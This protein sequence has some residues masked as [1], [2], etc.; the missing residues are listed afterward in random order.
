M[1]D[2]AWR[3]RI[4]GFDDVAPDQL[5]ANP[6]NWR[7]HPKHQQDALSGVLDQVGWVQSVLVNKRTGFVVDGHLRVALALRRN[8]PTVPVLYVDLSEDEEALVL[9][10]L[11]PIGALATADK[12]KLD[13]LLRDVD[14]GSAAVQAMLSELAER[15][16][17][18]DTDSGAP[19]DTI[20]EQW[21][22]LVTCK[23][24]SEQI[25]LIERMLS[26]GYECRAL[27]S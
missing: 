12:E 23:G 15:E 3:K 19:V 9:A 10:T 27:I 4:V 26:E 22:V 14:T 11:D 2:T 20:P 8:E 17:I 18:K 21:M 25:A 7:V 24:E 6:L 5:A 1:T 16:G 13:E